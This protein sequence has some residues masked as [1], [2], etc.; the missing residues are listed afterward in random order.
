MIIARVPQEGTGRLDLSDDANLDEWRVSLK[1]D[2]TPGQWVVERTTGPWHQVGALLPRGFA[3]YA[4]IFHPAYRGVSERG[5][6]E[7]RWEEVAVANG[8]PP[9][10]RGEVRPLTQIERAADIGVLGSGYRLRR[11]RRG[12]HVR[13]TGAG[14]G[15][16]GNRAA[17]ADGADDGADGR[18]TEPA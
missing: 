18:R 10:G 9:T 4:R 16:E 13:P 17:A 14:G 12:S 5:W 15:G 2:V 3:A 7:V 11:A 1:G 6:A 8:T